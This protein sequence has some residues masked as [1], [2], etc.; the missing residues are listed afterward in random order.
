MQTARIMRNVWP[1]F[2][3]I[4]LWHPPSQAQV[5]YNREDS[6]TVFSLIGRAEDFFTNGQH[7]SALH[8]CDMAEQYSRQ[9]GFKKGQAYA[10]IE[11]ADVYIDS[12]EL[13]KAD[14]HAAAVNKL[15][16]QLKDSLV[17]AI[18][19]MQMAQVKMYKGAYDDAVSLFGRSLQYYLA[20]HPTRY[21]ALAFNDLG[22]TWG[23]K[24]E[25][26]KKANCLIQAISIYE[27]HFP[28]EYGE[29]GVALN[30]LSTVYYELNQVDKAI[31][32]AKR[33]LVYREKTG[34]VARLSIGCCNI[35]QFYSGINNQE[36]EKYLQLCVKYAMQS[37]QESRMIHSYVTA[38]KVY[39]MNKKPAEAM[40]YELK[41]ISLLEKSGKDPAM[42]ANRY[43]AAG[44][45]GRQLNKDSALIMSY[46]KKSADI[47]HAQNNKTYLR[48]YYYQL[49]AFYNDNKNYA[50]AYESYKK[51][52]AYRDSL[53]NQNTQS[54]IAEIST[55]YETE[56][57]DNEISRLNT[58]QRIKQLE[59]EKQ[60]AIIDGNAA[61]ALQKQ[62]EIDLLSKSRELQEARI[63]QQGEELEKQQLQTT[64]HQQRLQLAEQERLLQDRQLKSQK[65][66]RNLLIGGIVLIVLLGLTYLNRYQLKKKLEQ[67]KSLQA[68]RNNISRDLH[69]DIGASLSNINILNELAKRNITQPDKSK[70][71]LSK[72][73]ED[74]QRISESLS[75]IVWNINPRYDELQ[76]LFIRMK[77]YAADMLDGKN[78]RGEFDFPGDNPDIQLSMTQR[79]D[80]YLIF[81][82]AVNNLVKYSGASKATI[83]FSTDKHKIA[84]T[85]ADNGRGFDLQEV[86][87]GNGLQNM[88]QRARASGGD[89]TIDSMPGR[90]TAVHL[91]MYVT[92]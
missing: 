68:M 23:I 53:I 67:Q 1:A 8:Y 18:S 92:G 77:R 50:A 59:I 29:L 14:A 31:D 20:A 65:Q 11:A 25:L 28:E 35:S 58:D 52:I 36:A 61:A 30:N 16:G 21:T 9:K 24:G 74:I 34:D 66:L 54:A 38:S 47:L 73:S 41:A 7:D 45:L 71:Y 33:S 51:Y 49:S 44:I 76:N 91:E 89:V 57:K 87:Q 81:K 88:L 19:W 39:A 37:N 27:N 56:K 3:F 2:I 15:G 13:D 46:F 80:L 86:K 78:I 43:V 83:R 72:A 22:Y 90:G 62:N 64:T 70:E 63:R 10:L 12:D 5:S 69:D 26:S 48:D 17:T 75:D 6:L 4:L 55:R 85:I 40:D 79:R 82:E 60:K 32:Y 84:M 42:L